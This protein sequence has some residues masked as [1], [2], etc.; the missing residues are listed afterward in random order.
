[1]A[2]RLRTKPQGSEKRAIDF[3]ATKNILINLSKNGTH[4]LYGK[5]DFYD[6][7]GQ[8]Y[9]IKTICSYQ[10]KYHLAEWVSFTKQQIKG[11]TNNDIIIM[12]RYFTK[13]PEIIIRFKHIK[14]MITPGGNLTI[15]KID[16]NK[17]IEL[18]GK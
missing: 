13:N 8:G 5:P 9:E 18:G 6:D 12:M 11:F 17:T 7:K 1:M 3:L 15:N 16:L 2:T 14:K 10:K 4:R